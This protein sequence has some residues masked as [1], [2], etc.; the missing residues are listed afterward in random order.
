VYLDK[1]MVCNLNLINLQS[2]GQLEK[3]YVESL[4]L[5]RTSSE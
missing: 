1:V 5:L 3:C 4:S 2:Q